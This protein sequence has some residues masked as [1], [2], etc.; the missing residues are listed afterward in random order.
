MI[1]D[2]GTMTGSPER[3]DV[4]AP[5]LCTEDIIASEV[6]PHIWVQ[7]AEDLQNMTKKQEVSHYDL[8]TIRPFLKTINA[9]LTRRRYTE[10]PIREYLTQI[11]PNTLAEKYI[12]FYDAHPAYK[13]VC[14]GA[15]HHHW[16]EGG[17][18]THVSEMIGICMDLMDLYPGDMVFT[19]TDVIIANFLHDF[20]KIWIYRK[21][22]DE[23]KQR[24]NK[25]HEKQVFTYRNNGKDDLMD[26]A[27]QIL[28]EL[29]KASITP[30]DMQWSAVLFHEAAFSP[31]AWSYKGPSRAMDHVMTKNLLAVLINMADMYSAHFLGRS[32]V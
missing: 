8:L 18:E 20:N 16:W 11:Q 6:V 28:L 32:L 9:R 29:S 21:I 22:T 10:T 3:L 2:E 19:K 31:A 24:P 5:V 25:F 13:I 4:A 27:S 7:E 23:D 17:L 12:E 26:G 14:A 15:K 1:V 30:T